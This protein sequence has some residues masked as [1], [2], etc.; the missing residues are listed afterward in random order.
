MGQY[1]DYSTIMRTDFKLIFFI[2][3]VVSNIKTFQISSFTPTPHTVI[4]MVS[5]ID[6]KDEIRSLQEKLNKEYIHHHHK[7]DK[8]PWELR[9]K[10][11][12]FTALAGRIDALIDSHL[13]WITETQNKIDMRSLYGIN[14]FQL[15]K[16]N[17]TSILNRHVQN[18]TNKVIVK[19]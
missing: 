17:I 7:E 16:N 19:N 1:F 3:I 15:S 9:K 8:T 10:R 2:H 4:R 13:N 11:P 14:P 6:P 18:S 12:L 5:L